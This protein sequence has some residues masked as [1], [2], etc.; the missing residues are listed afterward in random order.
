[1]CHICISLSISASLLRFLNDPRVKSGKIFETIL[2]FP[3]LFRPPA[4][5]TFCLTHSISLPFVPQ[6][7][8]CQLWCLNVGVRTHRAAGVYTTA[9]LVK[10]TLPWKYSHS[11][12][13]K[14]PRKIRVSTKHLQVHEYS[15]ETFLS[16]NP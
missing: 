12:H 16:R 10:N 11:V 14:T 9:T 7:V 2:C 1:M 5:C 6:G 3:V 4:P 15:S 13:S 8:C